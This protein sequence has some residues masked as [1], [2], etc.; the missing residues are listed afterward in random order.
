[1]AEQVSGQ[2]VSG[3]QVSRQQVSRQHVGGKQVSGQYDVVVLGGEPAGLSAAV[4]LARPRRGALVV[5]AGEP[6]NAASGHAHN[7]LGR[8]G[9]V[10]TRLLADGRAEAISHGARVLRGRVVHAGPAG[11]GADGGGAAINAD[12]IAEETRAAV[13]AHRAEREDVDD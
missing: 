9:V 13:A 5:D 8:E 4:A 12:L 10:P 3:Q 11:P 2:Q 7:Y 1:M 6:R